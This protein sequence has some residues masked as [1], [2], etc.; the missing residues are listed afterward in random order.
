MAIPSLA[1]WWV[2]LGMAIPNFFFSPMYYDWITSSKLAKHKPYF[3]VGIL[4]LTS[5]AIQL[6]FMSQHKTVFAE[7]AF[8]PLDVAVGED[9]ENYKDDLYTTYSYSL[10]TV[11]F[12][13]TFM[14]M[15]Y[16]RQHSDFKAK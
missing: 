10:F 4:Y 13:W 6:R 12:A 3:V 9:N 1:L 16:N 8:V 11:T 14:L 2:Y 5:L 15:Q 7:N